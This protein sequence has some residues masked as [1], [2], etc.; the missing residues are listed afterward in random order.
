MRGFFIRFSG[1][2][3]A[4]LIL[5]G[6]YWLESIATWIGYI[7]VFVA[8]FFGIQL[9]TAGVGVSEWGQEAAIRYAIWVLCLTAV[10]GLPERIQEEAMTGVLEQR[11]L[12]PKGGISNLIM[13]HIAEL[14]LWSFGTTLAFFAMVF[15][16]G[17]PVV[18]DWG[19]LPVVLL[20]LL[21]IEGVGFL[22]A[23]LALLFK[24]IGAVTQLL[25][26]ALLGLALLPADRLPN[27]WQQVIQT[28]PLAAG[29][30]LLN[31][32]LLRRIDFATA[33]SRSDFWVLLVSSAAYLLVGLV[34]LHWAVRW[35]RQHGLLSQY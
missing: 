11:F 20:V 33:V 6:R 23:G 19:I 8:I 27:T 31:D 22:L 2:L 7:I 28:L 15:V 16:S 29:L 13:S 30:P 12:A 5:N 32:L 3:Q 17:T 1:E 21:G 34:G 26:M 10:V 25:Q 9:I 4:A 14:F 24:R 18:L 35:V